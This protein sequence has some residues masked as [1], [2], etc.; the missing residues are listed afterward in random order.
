MSRDPFNNNNVE[1]LFRRFVL[2]LDG[3]WNSM[4]MP[5][6]QRIFNFDEIYNAI[7][8]SSPPITIFDP[9]NKDLRYVVEDRLRRRRGCNGRQIRRIE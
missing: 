7:S 1:E 4:N 5:D 8:V 6:E 2:E 3:M 9:D